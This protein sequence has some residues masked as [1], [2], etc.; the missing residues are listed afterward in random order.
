MPLDYFFHILILIGIFALLGASM[1]IVVGYTGLINLSHV[2]LYGIGA[3][4]SAI[5]SLRDVPYPVAFMSAGVITAVIG[6]IFICLTEKLQGDYFALATLGF[7]FMITALMQNWMSLT[8]G[9]LGIPGIPRPVFGSIVLHSPAMYLGYTVIIVTLS[10]LFLV[11]L[12]RSR[13]G[14]LL[15]AVRDDAIGAAALGKNIFRIK[16][17]S[18]V[19][20]A[21]FAG[22]AGSLFAHY[23][24]YIDPTVFFIT[25][26][27]VLLTLVIVGGLASLK[28]SVVAAFLVVVLP[29]LLRFISFPPNMIGSARQFL[30]AVSLLAIIRYRPRGLFGRVDLN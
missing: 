15:E 30:Y 13:Y 29:E 25:Q 28:G 24:R 19:I 23:V 21:F 27:V 4:A 1:N 14:R 26:M 22:I 11:R 18:M 7:S 2:A 9:P 5:L 12:T 20:S 6:F 16:R 8:R 10:F 17:E 3:Y